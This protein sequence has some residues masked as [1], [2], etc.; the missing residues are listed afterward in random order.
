L[1]GNTVFSSL[2]LGTNGNYSLIFETSNSDRGR[3][4]G[5]GN[6]GIGTTD[7]SAKLHVNSTVSSEIPFRVQVLGNT[8]FLTHSNGRVAIGASITPP[9]NG[10]YVNGNT[11]F[12][13]TD[14]GP[15]RARVLMNG[16]FGLDIQNSTTLD[17]WEL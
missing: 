9:T 13:T 16:A 10:L 8:K 6:W 3:I 1:G 7:P 5:G 14:P 15:C 11:G 2:R 17:D 12:G 4:T